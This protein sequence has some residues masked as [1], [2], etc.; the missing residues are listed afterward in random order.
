MPGEE[1]GGGRRGNPAPGAVPGARERPRRQGEVQNPRRPLG[2][3]EPAEDVR[4][5]RREAI[6]GEVL[7]RFV[8]RVPRGQQDLRQ[9]VVLRAAVVAR[10][11]VRVGA[12]VGPQFRKLARR[13]VTECHRVQS[14]SVSSF[15]K[16]RI[17]RNKCTRTVDSFKPVISPT[18]RAE[19]PST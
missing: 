2:V 11:D 14:V 13:K 4:V 5:L 19:W 1:P 3:L 18:S 12:A 16:R 6:G 7:V 17:A 9:R 8:G 10:R 15:R